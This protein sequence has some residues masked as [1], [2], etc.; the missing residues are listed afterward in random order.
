[1]NT[2]INNLN[3]SGLMT[4]RLKGLITLL[5]VF[6]LAVLTGCGGAPAAP[7]ETQDEAPPIKQTVPE[8]TPELCAD[9]KD[10]DEDGFI[11]CNDPG[12][13]DTEGFCIGTGGNGAT[14]GDG[15]SPTWLGEA[16]GEALGDVL[17][18]AV[19]D[20]LGSF[21]G[22]FVGRSVGCGVSSGSSGAKVGG[23]VGS[24]VGFPLGEVV[25]ATVGSTVGNLGSSAKV[26]NFMSSKGFAEQNSSTVGT[27][28][29]GSS[30]GGPSGEFRCWLISSTSG[31]DGVSDTCFC[32]C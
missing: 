1:M 13:L 24:V 20:E 7:Q 26:Q 30:E 11:D 8:D 27:I 6:Q 21:V 29:V 25:G 32:V 19:G 23:C 17:G 10:N 28:S 5:A 18:D 9:G 15:V 2:T 16:L 3:F 4:Q 22:A 14:D 12:C 31:S